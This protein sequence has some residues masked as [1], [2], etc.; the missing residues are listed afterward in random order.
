[1]TVLL[2]AP[3]IVTADAD[4]RN[5]WLL[6]DDDARSTVLARGDGVPPAHGRVIEHAGTVLPAFVD[7]HAHG[8][9]GADFASCSVD[10][11]RSAAAHHAA[12]GTGTLV[13]SIATGTLPDTITLYRIPIVEVCARPED[14][15]AKVRTVLVHEVGH[16]MGL[17]EARLREL[18][19]A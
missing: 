9:L 14:V 11:A 19:W 18:G 8:A 2:R 17:G 4:L 1:M 5:G 13:A 7:L 12:R 10:D 15:P 6:L 16:A 3:R